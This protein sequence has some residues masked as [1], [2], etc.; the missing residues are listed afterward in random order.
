MPDYKSHN[1]NISQKAV[2][3]FATGCYAGTIPFAPGTFGSVA[4]LPLCFAISKI[5]VKAA[6]ICLFIFILAAIL[7]SHEAAKT[8]KQEDPGCIVIDEIAGMMITFVGIPFNI[9]SAGSGFVI[10][11][12]FDIIKPFPVR[13]LEKKISGGTGIVIDDVAAG[14]LSNI[15]LRIFLVLTGQI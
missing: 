15:V 9:V 4:A 7:I 12:A 8:L 5:G 2:I 13:T 14:I 6:I 3:F 11:R 1:I 10:F